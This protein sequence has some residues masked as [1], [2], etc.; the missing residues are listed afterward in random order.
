MT[1]DEVVTDV[2]TKKNPK[3]T[4]IPLVLVVWLIPDTLRRTKRKNSNV[5][6]I[7]FLGKQFLSFNRVSVELSRFGR[8][9][10]SVW[11]C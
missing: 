5:L 11:A 1:G 4:W 6:S 3:T 10:D 2:G 7:L 8:P 9:A